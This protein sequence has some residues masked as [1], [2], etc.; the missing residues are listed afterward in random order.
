MEEIRVHMDKEGRI[1][2]PAELRKGFQ[3]GETFVL[4][5]LEGELRLI[6]LKQA[7]KNAQD[8]AATIF[9]N[10]DVSVDNFLKSRKEDSG[11]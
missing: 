11:E 8:W 2:I 4:R 9:I 6:S 1:R 10:S 3:P 5:K 7:V